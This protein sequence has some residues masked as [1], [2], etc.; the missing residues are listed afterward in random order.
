M[1]ETRAKLSVR[2]LLWKECRRLSLVLS[3][4]LLLVF[5]VRVRCLVLWGCSLLVL[6]KLFLPEEVQEGSK[7]YHQ[8]YRESIIEGLFVVG[9][10]AAWTK[11]G[12]ICCV[13]LH[14]LDCAF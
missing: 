14:L 12:P 9:E 8:K 11:S 1:A 10:E 7:G 13:K 4:L 6:S 5:K 3:G 2:Q